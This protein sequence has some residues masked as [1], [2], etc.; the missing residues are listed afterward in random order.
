MSTA[1]KSRPISDTVV[2]SIGQRPP[3]TSTPKVGRF[4]RSC[5]LRRIATR[6]RSSM[7]TTRHST[8]ASRRASSEIR[9]VLSTIPAENVTPPS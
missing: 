9:I 8:A 7:T 4:C 5:S 1:T 6:L 3:R 2:G